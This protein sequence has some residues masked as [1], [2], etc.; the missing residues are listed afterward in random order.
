MRTISVVMI[1]GFMAFVGCAAS[2]K[3]MDV[4][5]SNL[6]FQTR[7]LDS[8]EQHSKRLE[9]FHEK[10]E[11]P[12]EI[13][14][15]Q[16]LLDSVRSSGLI[17]IRNGIAYENSMAVKWLKRKLHHKRLRTNPIRSAI[18]FIERCA[19]KSNTTGKP[20][21]VKWDDG[22]LYESS[23]ILRYE[24]DALEHSLVERNLERINKESIPAIEASSE[25][26]VQP[27]PEIAIPPTP[28]PGI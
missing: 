2:P 24:L 23:A 14:K 9:A 26:Q 17:F 19:T 28:V 3:N 7:Y 10:Y 20:Y 1:C 15:I 13:H 16:F 25:G 4:L 18:D 22:K 21:F 12:R 5:P 8:D 11:N 6:Q 27:T